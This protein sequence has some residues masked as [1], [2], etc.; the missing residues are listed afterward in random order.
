M[1]GFTLSNVFPPSAST[2]F[3]SISSLGSGF[4]FG[5][6]QPRL[7]LVSS[8]RV[9]N[10]VS[11]MCFSGQPISEVKLVDNAEPTVYRVP[12]GQGRGPTVGPEPSAWV[13]R[14]LSRGEGNE[15][16]E[17]QGRSAIV[18]GGRRGPRGGHRPAAGRPGVRV[19]V[20]DR[21][22]DRAATLAKELG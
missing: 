4:T 7:M 14:S 11:S 13:V 5:A 6:S 2:S 18:T 19:T 17:V 15:L 22:A 20:F 1:A 10:S 9:D 16:M 8:T 3:P 21:D 12:T